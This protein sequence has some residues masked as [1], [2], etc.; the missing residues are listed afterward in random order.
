MNRKALSLASDNLTPANLLEML[1]LAPV[2]PTEDDDYDPNDD[3]LCLA[4][5]LGRAE[6][7]RRLSTVPWL[8]DHL[9]TWWPAGSGSPYINSYA[10]LARIATASLVLQASHP[11][12]LA[13]ALSLPR[14]CCYVMAMLLQCAPFGSRAQL[15][16]VEASSNPEVFKDV[17]TE[18]LRACL[19]NQLSVVDLLK[20]VGPSLYPQADTA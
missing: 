9:C 19:C 5:P 12:D 4:P 7:L 11:E 2:D 3:V 20:C 15:D 17:V 10:V 18:Y 13:F 6:V 14:S 16:R 1:Q 8:G